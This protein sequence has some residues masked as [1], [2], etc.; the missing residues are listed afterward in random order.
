[1]IV[2][3][4]LSN[5]NQILF[6]NWS[7]IAIML[8]TSCDYCFEQPFKQIVNTFWKT[9]GFVNQV[10]RNS[11]YFIH[12]FWLCFRNHDYD[13]VAA[14]VNFVNQTSTTRVPNSGQ[15]STPR[16]RSLVRPNFDHIS[17][18]LWIYFQKIW[19]FPRSYE[20]LFKGLFET[21]VILFD[22]KLSEFV[23]QLIV[24]DDYVTHKL[25]LLFDQ[26]LQHIIIICV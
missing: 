24:H 11:D 19:L 9:S 22:R 12:K 10:V 5:N 2:C 25:W 13:L 6:I 26:H 14:V 17:F 21:I 3:R 4:C 7:E 20:Y 18:K 15:T 23:D 8:S 16:C 1:M